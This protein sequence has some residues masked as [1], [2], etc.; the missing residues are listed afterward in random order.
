MQPPPLDAQDQV[1]EEAYWESVRKGSLDVGEAHVLCAL[2]T[3]CDEPDALLQRGLV[4]V[5]LITSVV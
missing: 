5:S 3:L 4:C 2:L 1:L